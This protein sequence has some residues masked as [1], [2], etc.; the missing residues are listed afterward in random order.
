MFCS[1]HVVAYDSVQGVMFPAMH[2]MLG[3]WA[4]P[5][6]RSFFASM[7]IAGQK[8]KNQFSEAITV[9][10]Y[11]LAGQQYDISLCRSVQHVIKW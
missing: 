4:P 1:D 11:N 7:V 8:Q 3:Q 6:E 9:Y 5:L 2:A 10:V